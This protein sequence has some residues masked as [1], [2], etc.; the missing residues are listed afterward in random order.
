MSFGWWL[1]LVGMILGVIS[2]VAVIFGFILSPQDNIFRSIKN[3][4]Q[5]HFGSGDNIAG[6]KIELTRFSETQFIRLW[7]EHLGGNDYLN[8]DNLG[9][10]VYLEQS[11]EGILL[12][13]NS[14]QI[15]I[16]NPRNSNNLI[17]LGGKTA[18]AN[19]ENS[20]DFE[21]R[22]FSVISMND[23]TATYQFDL[24]KQK[25]HTI[26]LGGRRFVVTFTKINK[27][28]IPSVSAPIEYE[29]G[30]SEIR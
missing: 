19:P 16:P 9:K 26:E 17:A 18:V 28:N 2:S 27:P 1:Q 3:T 11:K 15:M 5:I 8:L 22:D 4:I 24:L 29:F 23:E 30:I 10:L 6:E 21:M 25:T 7:P 13:L 20:K 14:P 12:A